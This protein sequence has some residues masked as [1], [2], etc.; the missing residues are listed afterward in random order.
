MG[1]WDKMTGNEGMDGEEGS[2]FQM[3]R[4]FQRFKFG[5]AVSN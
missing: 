5:K 1:P 3:M 4:P 2:K